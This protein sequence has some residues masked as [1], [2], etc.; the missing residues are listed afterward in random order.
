MLAE[1]FGSVSAAALGEAAVC[2]GTLTVEWDTVDS[3]ASAEEPVDA[4]GGASDVLAA[5]IE[6]VA[7]PLP[8]AEDGPSIDDLVAR[9]GTV[10][11]TSPGDASDEDW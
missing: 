7:I 6:Q 10:V 1:H 5:A 4:V 2:V 3:G 11:D 8:W 9:G